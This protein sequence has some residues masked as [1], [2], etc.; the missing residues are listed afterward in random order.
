M[1]DDTNSNETRT[2]NGAVHR[3]GLGETPEGENS[4]YVLPDRGVVVDP[5]PPVDAAWTR[6]RAGV[7]AVTDLDAVDHVLVTHWH[8]DHAG[9]APR[10]A[11]AAD[12][13]LHLH[14]ADAP[15]VAD[16]ATE[17]ARRLDRDRERL[18]AWGVPDVLVGRLVEGD[19]PSPVPDSFPVAPLRDG[20]RIA[21]VE[22]L[23]APG[24]TAGH[25][26]FLIHGGDDATGD[27][28]ASSDGASGDDVT[29]GDG[30]GGT[31]AAAPVPLVGDL[32]LPATTPNVGG[33]DTRLDDPLPTYLDSLDRLASRVAADA[34]AYPGH[35]EPFR[36]APRVGALRDHHAT[37]V[38]R[39]VTAVAAGS[40]TPWAVARSLFGE[41]KG[42]HAKMGAGEAASHLAAAADRGRLARVADDPIRYTAE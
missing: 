6:L 26:V 11:E 38:E 3:V 17:R 10:L 33:G 9:L 13:T 4:A 35:G 18:L 12:A 2:P 30:S 15:L 41:M 23:H 42:V 34:N 20:D 31:G 14:T 28:D 22:C 8:V 27:N 16:Y 29:D 36:L 39:C 5:G 25:A 37:R 21:G 7:D 40:A 19:T 1:N 32:V 24:H